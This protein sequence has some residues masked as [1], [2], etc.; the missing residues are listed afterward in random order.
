MKLIK[1]ILLTLAIFLLLC[2]IGI[3]FF[4][5]NSKPTYSG[6]ISLAGPSANIEVLYDDFGIP[7]IYAQNETDAYFALGYVHAQDR[8]FQME[9]LRRAASGRLSEII[10]PDM[11]QVDKL[12]RTLRINQ[13]AEEQAKKFLASDTSSFQRAALAYQ[14][15]I[16]TFIREGATPIEFT[17]MGI[18]KTEFT[19]KDIYIAI[20]F[21][22][23]GFAEGLKVD[24]VLEKIKTQWGNDYLKDLAVETPNDAARIPSFKG[25]VKTIDP[26]IAA[27]HTAIETLPVPLLTGSNGWVISGTRTKSGKPILA[28]DTHIGYGQPAVWYE[29]HLEYPGFSLYG[30]HLA[31][32]PFAMLGQNNFCGW[33]LTMFE[34][35]DTDF[36]I[37]TTDAA[38]PNQVKRVD[39]WADVTTAEEI[40]K[41]KGEA[42]VLH[43]VK[44]T[45]HGPI[46][47]G[48]IQHVTEGD[49][50]IALDW[51]LLHGDNTALQ[52]SYQLN[53]TDSFAEA[54]HAVSL[55]TAPGL[56]VM[57]A[58]VAGNIAWWAAAKLPK[59]KTRASKFFLDASTGTDDYDGYYAFAD[60][61]QS[62][63]PPSGFVYS[64]NN[65]PEVV[66][67]NFFPGYYFPRDRAA[68]IVTL[69]SEEKT[70]TVDN[71][72]N[73][74]LD[75]TSF[76]ATKVAKEIASVLEGKNVD[77]LAPIYSILS[78]WNGDHQPNDVGPSVYYNMLSQ[79]VYLAMADEIGSDA[80][81]SIAN[82]SLLKNS[83][84]GLISNE[85]SVWWD[86]VKT[87]SI[88]ESRADIFVKSA[89][90]TLALLNLTSGPEPAEWAWGKIHT[91]KHNHPLGKV[92]LLDGMFSVGPFS[93][94]G[95]NEVI[96][97]FMFDLDTTGYFEV[98]GG[99]ALRKI[100]D[101]S[102]MLN[103]ETASPTGQ[104][105]NV[106]S[107]FYSDQAEMFANGKFRKML[108]RRED[109]EKV[110]KGKLVLVPKG[111]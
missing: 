13:F 48:I 21:M 58:D 98:K 87:K 26:L 99:P 18:P 68:R 52:A 105:G 93:V 63:N 69:L 97:N 53:H 11:V 47:N 94:A 23:F 76:Q 19:P 31:G 3:F 74:A 25:A 81:F 88:R 111:K 30:H 67:G 22:S 7:H 62:V 96:N 35:D 14:K 38:H 60:N 9:M 75:V 50:W 29:A 61:P 57:Y 46:V 91:L 34:N 56:N 42:D 107:D 36:F 54:N 41:V 73:V 32:V 92:S 100:T 103:G 108:M 45:S 39:G 79:I 71:V 44:V 33:G 65:Q 37:E 83:Y 85:S 1:R 5:Q 64:A 78:Q 2:A 84:L 10:G 27:I 82:G 101:F 90:N 102:E 51:Q 16:N 110:V 104:S 20:G 12:F 106:M 40:I 80:V 24:P 28:N 86:N 95:G 109:I 15:G 66:H 49:D 55:F 8:L 4:L 72:K 70:W 43:E 17:I 77:K 6:E 89:E 59:R